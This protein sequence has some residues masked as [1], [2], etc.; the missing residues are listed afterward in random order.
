MAGA[1]AGGLAWAV[2]LPVPASTGI[3]VAVW[4]AAI[5]VVGHLFGGLAGPAS[6]PEDGAAPY[7][8]RAAAARD[9][10]AAAAA[11]LRGGPGGPVADHMA[12]GVAATAAAV[13]RLEAARPR[14]AALGAPAAAA[15]A[16]VGHRIQAG[17]RDLEEAAAA[18][19]AA[20]GGPDALLALARRIDAVGYG[21]AIAER[22]AAEALHPGG[23]AAP[24]GPDEYT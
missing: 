12:A 22:V 20:V 11:A 14:L 21:V 19:P 1:T 16:E 13:A 2:G 18:L 8:A 15:T 24:P 5:L 17:T 23:P 3:G 9:A 4:L 7:A 6:G 10:F